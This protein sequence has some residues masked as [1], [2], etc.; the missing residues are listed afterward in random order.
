VNLITCPETYSGETHCGIQTTCAYSWFKKKHHS[1]C[2][3][4]KTFLHSSSLSYH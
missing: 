3:M 2:G 4:E 1:F